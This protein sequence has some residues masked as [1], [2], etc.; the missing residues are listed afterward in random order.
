MVIVKASDGN[1]TVYGH[2]DP[3]VN[4]GTS[5]SM[6]DKIGRCDLS[7]D[8]TGHHVHM[9]RLP[10]GDNSVQGVLDRQDSGVNF[11]CKGEIV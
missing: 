11:K 1:V 5:V 3:S 4:K 7:G 2:V 9:V 6:G 10:D 8:S